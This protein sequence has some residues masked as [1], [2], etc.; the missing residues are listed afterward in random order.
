[1]RRRLPDGE[2]T[3][4][5]LG[6]LAGQARAAGDLE[7]AERYCRSIAILWPAR[8][9]GYVNALGMTMAGAAPTGL[10]DTAAQLRR[11]R[12]LAGADGRVLRNLGFVATHFRV[13]ELAEDLLR[14]TL[15]VQ[16][17]DARAW[18]V[19][20]H[21]SAAT[22]GTQR[23]AVFLNPGDA[24]LLRACV[25]LRSTGGDWPGV[26]D[27][28]RSAHGVDLADQPDLIETQTEALTVLGRLD[29]AVAGLEERVSLQTENARIWFR[30]GVLL[31][32]ADRM[33][34]AES[35]LR[36]AMVLDPESAHARGALARVE[37]ADNRPET[38]LRNLAR[39]RVAAGDF[40][41]S[42]EQN[43]AAALIGLRRGAEARSTLRRLLV[44]APQNVGT[45]LNI[46]T[47]EQFA[48]D[49]E[50]AE[51]WI[52]RARAMAP[53]TGSVLL[54]AGLIARYAG[55]YTAA[56]DHFDALLRLEPGHPQATY[57]RACLELQDGDRRRGAV[58]FLQRFRIED[59]SSARRLHPEPS[60][61]QPV[62]DL[63]PVPDATV[64]IWGEQGIGDEVW[65]AQFL[66]GIRGRAGR[67]VLEVSGKLVA[68]LSRTFPWI[69]VMA[70]EEPATEAVAATADLQLPLGHLIALQA[71]HPP[72]S[73]YLAVNTD[74]AAALRERYT[75]RFPGKRLVGISW[76]SIKPA[77]MTRSFEA[78]LDCWGPIF[79]LPD[80]KIISLQYAPEEA[81]FRRTVERFGIKLNADP[82][83]DT[84]DDI[85]GLAALVRSLDAVVSIANSTVSIAN[86][87]GT[88]AY[89]PL[90]ALQD[91]F[92]YPH[93]G[94]RSHWLPGVRFSW[95]PRPDR[96]ETALAALADDI[97]RDW[98]T[99]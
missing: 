4:E 14:R 44:D 41:V 39:A 89:V 59:F 38:A 69:E 87:V 55:D 76:R 80:T 98:S 40:R 12:T 26:L 33:E 90:R 28:L 51:T 27:L 3:P 21:R 9:T 53:D 1:M 19:H 88:P 8:A 29:E 72:R 17:D 22:P 32:R 82:K 86:G 37:L 47:A 78:P 25:M 95:A 36:R 5:S 79:M 97:R 56:R 83:V 63:S 10:P 23:V 85:G 96:W 92:R 71:D 73:D 75:R 13:E 52:R 15:L 43:W 93:Q 34:E 74:L 67:V 94:D 2:P 68:L 46:A 64:F 31:R 65:F 42:L 81:D 57:Y 48:L 49:F 66:E 24:D 20:G 70:R 45:T 58:D 77:A 84:T 62:W 18:R 7:R 54:N 91:D 61:P 50:A 11:G 16:P 6:R 30:L 35:A 99:G 60:L